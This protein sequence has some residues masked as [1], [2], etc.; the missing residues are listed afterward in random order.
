M[1]H[2]V[3]CWFFVP[4]V[5]DAAHWQHFVFMLLYKSIKIDV[6]LLP[7]V[8][9][10]FERPYVLETIQFVVQMATKVNFRAEMTVITL[11]L[12]RFNWPF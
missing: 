12:A 2:S 3:H 7:G 10:Y 5:S 6:G 1:E 4:Y 11:P 8:C 9:E